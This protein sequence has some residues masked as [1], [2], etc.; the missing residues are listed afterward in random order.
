MPITPNVEFTA[1][2]LPDGRKRVSV[3]YPAWP[4]NSYN[5]HNYTTVRN[6]D[7]SNRLMS[8]MGGW[9]F[10]PHDLEYGAYAALAKAE[11][12]PYQWA[13]CVPEHFVIK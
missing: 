12:K 4:K 2:I 5:P 1:E 11:G 8:D 9:S 3:F 7:G 10:L 13:H 6:I